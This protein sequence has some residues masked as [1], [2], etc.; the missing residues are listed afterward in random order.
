M[1]SS[2]QFPEELSGKRDFEYITPAGRRLTEY[3]AVTVYTQWGGHAGGS[4]QTMGDFLL[5]PDGRPVFD[6]ASTKIT[7]EDWYAYRDPNQMW[8]RPYY[9]TQSEAEKSIERATELVISTGAA[10]ALDPHWVEGGLVGTY[11]PFAHYEYGLFRGLNM[12]AREALSD[13]VNNVLVFLAADKLRHAQAISI[14]GLDLEGVYENFDGTAG[15]RIWLEDSGWQP[16]RRLIEEAMTVIDWNETI[17][18]IMLAIEPMIG[19]PLRRLVFGTGAAQRRDLLVPVAAGTATID[20]QRNAK[21]IRAYLEFLCTAPGGEANRDILAGWL[22]T[23]REKARTVA[24][25]FFEMIE[26]ALPEPGLAKQA[27]AVGDE[28]TQRVLPSAL[29][30]VASAA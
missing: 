23:W 29:A 27:A 16:L 5:R 8:Q 3:E 24:E 30:R 14:M 28:E 11:F 1:G 9:V 18:A 12:A 7:V 10:K 19:E 26:G 22:Q 21:A 17:V 6:P 2:G 25:G 13:S 4:L 20:W 15:K